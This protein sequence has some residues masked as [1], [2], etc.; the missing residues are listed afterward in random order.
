MTGEKVGVS[1]GKVRRGQ[2]KGLRE[3]GWGTWSE[4]PGKAVEVAGGRGREAARRSA[5]PSVCRTWKAC[6]RARFRT[7]VRPRRAGGASGMWDQ[8]LVRLALVQQLRAAYGIK[9]KGGR[10][11][12]ERRRRDSAAAAVVVSPGGDSGCGGGGGPGR[13][14]TAR[15][16]TTRSCRRVHSVWTQKRRWLRASDSI[17]VATG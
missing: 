6:W 7:R 8:R 16:V 14:S 1:E 5:Q 11:Q 4:E 3:G 13:G 17:Q 2:I 12:G 9:V 10:G 15:T